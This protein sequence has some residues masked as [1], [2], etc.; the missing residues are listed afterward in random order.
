[1][2]NHDNSERGSLFC[3]LP[4]EDAM[5]TAFLNAVLWSAA[6][7]VAVLGFA[8]SE[9]ALDFGS[10]IPCR[11]KSCCTARIMRSIRARFR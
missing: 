9:L 1:M 4:Q 5:R 3:V 6:P 7:A 11:R 10:D 8:C 2:R